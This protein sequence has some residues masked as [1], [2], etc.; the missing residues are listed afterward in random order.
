MPTYSP[1]DIAMALRP[2]EQG[3]AAENDAVAFA[4]TL[5]R[6]KNQQALAKA[7]GRT[8]P[9][10]LA[11]EAYGA[12]TAPGDALMGRLDPMS[13]QGIE[14]VNNLAGMLTLGAGAM[15][16]PQGALGMG[17]ARDDRFWHGVSKTKL[18][19]PIEEMSATHTPK[20]TMEPRRDIDIQKLQGG[21][22]VPAL[23][24][25]TAAGT[26]LT[27]IN[28]NKLAYPVDMQGGAD[29]MRSGN[30]L[31]DKPAWASQRGV[32]T[33][34]SNKVKKAAEIGDPYLAHVAMSPTSGDY[35]HM[36][37]D[38]LLA[39]LPTSKITK[40]MQRAFDADMAKNNKNWPGLANYDKLRPALLSGGKMKTIFAE[41]MA[42]GKYQNAGFPDIGATRKAIIEPGLLDAKNLDTGYAMAKLDPSGRVIPNPAVP[43]T[44]YD[45]QLAGQGYIGSM[46]ENIPAEIAFRDWF[47]SP[48]AKQKTDRSQLEYTFRLDQPTQKIDQQWIDEVSNYLNIGR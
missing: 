5:E 9:A 45:T 12:V 14:R 31:P 36:M 13:N 27:H 21:V 25:R 8:W 33:N 17:A 43:H 42:K 47:K 44:T 38:A 37:A 18:S 2:K 19:R 15:S 10:Q 32:V 30:L 35:S 22:L 20:G 3:V 28:E 46:P 4:G 26:F 39:Q 29:F 16:K 34:L 41:T 24:D 7:L 6:E 11:K 48:R 1:I 23:G 40:T